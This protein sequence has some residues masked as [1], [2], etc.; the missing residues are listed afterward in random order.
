MSSKW[1]GRK[2]RAIAQ[3]VSRWLP[4]RAA[5]IRTQVR[6]CGICGGQSGTGVGLLRVLRFTLPILIPPTAPHS[7][8]IIRGWYSRPMSGR[9]NMWTQSHPTPTKL[10]NGASGRCLIEVPAPQKPSVRVGDVPAEI[11]T[12]YLLETS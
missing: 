6:S 5:R 3:V 8:S 12:G 10:K 11:G 4:T 9:P 1:S 2:V 7:S